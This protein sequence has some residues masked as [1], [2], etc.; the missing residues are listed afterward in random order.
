M[1]TPGAVIDA[2]GYAL[3]DVPVRGGDLRVGAWGQGEVVALGVHGVTLNHAAFHLL[4]ETIA[5]GGGRL[6]APDLRGRGA[7]TELDAPYGLD[8]HVE[9]IVA[10]LNALARQPVVLV[11]HSWGA[12]VALAVAHRHPE[13][14]RGVLLI[15]GGLPPSP[16]SGSAQAAER[17]SQRVLDRLA[18]SFESVAAY[19]A[20]WKAYAGLRAYWN[21]YVE[22]AFA[23]DLTGTAPALRCNLRPDAFLADVE[24][25]Y[26]GD[27]AERA[28]VEASRP[29]IL[30]RAGRNMLDEPRPQYPD[31]V[32][33]PWLGRA[34]GLR[35]AFLGEESH[36]TVLLAASGAAAV[37]SLVREAF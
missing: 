24:S 26:A 34:P 36:Y 37:A 8:A 33:E 19:L 1:G 9:D 7:S 28:L 35:D 14:V 21:P 25:A 32:V 27:R 16:G 10:T 6:L 5:A 31:A 12:V 20:S 4:G 29:L 30:V 3:L 23:H 17:A 2:A 18:A 13:L 11:G 22:R 15:D